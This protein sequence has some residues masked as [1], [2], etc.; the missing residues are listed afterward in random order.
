[1]KNTIERVRIDDRHIG[2]GA[3]NG[4]LAGY[5]EVPVYSSVVTGRPSD[6]V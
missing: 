3:G 1:M 6:N 4:Q 5:I 2:A